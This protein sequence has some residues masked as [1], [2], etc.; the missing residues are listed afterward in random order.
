MTYD[1]LV[2]LEHSLDPAYREG[3]R[4]SFMFA[5]TT[6]KAI[7]KLKDGKAAPCGF[8]ASM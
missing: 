3:G 1:D 8:P 2:E 5:D 7:K 6:L 4:C